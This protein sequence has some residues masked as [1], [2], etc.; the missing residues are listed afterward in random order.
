MDVGG[1]WRKWLGDEEGDPFPDNGNVASRT[2]HIA[3]YW[4]ALRVQRAK[5]VSATPRD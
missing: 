3:V 1:P 5:D 4:S 2:V